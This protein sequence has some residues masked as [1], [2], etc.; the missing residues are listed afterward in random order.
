MKKNKLSSIKTILIL[1]FIQFFGI[2]AQESLNYQKPP[3]E[4]LE[5]V[6]VERAPS[7][8]ID[9]KHEN[10]LFTFRKMYKNLE[11]LSQEDIRLGGLRVNPKTNISSTVTYITNL[12]VRKFNETILKDVDGLPQQAKIANITWSPNEKFIAF[13]N[14][15]SNGL[16]LWILDINQASAKKW[17]NEI[18]NAN[19][20][21]PIVWFKN[22]ESVLIKTIIANRPVLISNSS[23]IP[24]GPTVTV[25]EKGSKAQNRTY[26]DLLKNKIDEQNFETLVSSEIKQVNLD[27]NVYPWKK[28]G[29]YTSITFSPNGN[30]VLINILEKPF[31]Y[32]VPYQRFPLKSAVFDS[33]GKIVKEV[34]NVPLIEIL[35]KGFMAVRKGKR[36][37]Y[38]R[39]DKPASLYFVEA[40]DGGDPETIVEYRDELFSW[41]APFDQTPISLVKTKQRFS[42]VEWGTAQFAFVVEEWWNTR[43]T[44]TIVFNPSDVN[45][46]PTVL[47]DRNS[48][49]EY[50]NPGNF[51]MKRNEF[52]LDVVDITKN[53]AILIGDGHTEKGQFPFIDKI[54]L[55]TGKK[56]RLY[57]SSFTDK[58]ESILKFL[59]PLK[60]DVLIQIES[61]NEF[62]NYYVRN[63]KSK[64]T[65][66]ALTTF[67]N[68]FKSIENVN[69]QLITYKRKDGVELS[70][71]LYLP[72]NYE[73][74]KKYPMIMWAYPQEFKDKNSAGQV[75]TNPNEFVFPFYGSPIYWVTRGYVVLD[76]AAFP[77]LG[78]GK[79]EPND[80]FI[81]QL[82]DNAKAA[83]DEV[84]KMGYIDRTK[85]AIGGHSYG[86]FMTANLLTHSDLF[87]C[88]VAR[89]GAYNRTLTPFGFQSEERSYWDVPNIYNSMSPFMTADKMNHNLLLIHGEADN[90]PGT[91]TLQSERYFNA[92]KGLGKPA[93]LV[94]LPKESH[95]YAAIES[96]L[97]VLWEQDQWFEKFMK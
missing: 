42:Y 17:C 90:N 67:Q 82:V 75:T 21:N 52:G 32:L 81:E 76:D 46:K 14:T 8:L 48:Q 55:L 49:D 3:R 47:F 84:D 13:T 15:T 27:G 36:N 78:E 59:D 72:L 97:H 60:G 45:Q 11:D 19:F 62:P 34:N 6:D 95:G 71:T 54:N 2:Q 26:Q 12:K 70:G 63:I 56:S 65:P 9:S 73:K 85:V 30:Y 29:L 25:S 23:A 89:S 87:V 74:G 93:R 39:E 37:M 64:K 5:L 44:K 91:F 4:I 31:S 7:V 79:T 50:S 10:M 68:P 66:T 57:Q 38:W 40:Q 35:P 53:E 22:S 88:G 20:G 94:V 80:S 1:F 24:T 16:E 33:R 96:I 28:V 61:K 69:K 92:L 18:L 51:E 83:I 41:D 77:I 58:K 43:N 86:A